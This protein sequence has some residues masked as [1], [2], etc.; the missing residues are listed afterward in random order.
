MTDVWHVLMNNIE[1][2]Y[3]YSLKY[4]HAFLDLLT[5]YVF[6]SH[7]HLTYHEKFF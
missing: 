7:T 4:K 6:L 3:Y 5:M 1:N 2:I